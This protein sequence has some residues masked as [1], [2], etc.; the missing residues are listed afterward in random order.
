MNCIQTNS[1]MCSPYSTSQHACYPLPISLV[2]S[3][4]QGLMISC[5]CLLMKGLRA[6]NS[7]WIVIGYQSLL[8]ANVNLTSNPP[9]PPPCY[10]PVHI[11]VIFLTH[12]VMM[13]MMR[14]IRPTKVIKTNLMMFFFFFLL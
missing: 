9:P 13:M 14:R 10:F 8:N 7:F 3:G 5:M 4:T 6:L 12:K 2:P 1:T 11:A